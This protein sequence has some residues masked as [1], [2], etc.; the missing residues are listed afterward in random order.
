MFGDDDAQ[1]LGALGESNDKVA[2]GKEWNGVGR[3]SCVRLFDGS[4]F[5]F[6][7]LAERLHSGRGL[8]AL[9]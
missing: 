7:F 4:L 3:L 8:S 9:V 6:R 1:V 2:G 5:P